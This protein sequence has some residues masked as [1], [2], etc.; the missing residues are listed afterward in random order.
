MHPMK[1]PISIEAV[2]RDWAARGF[3][4][5]LWV[6]PPGREWI[7]YVHPVDELILL[8][9]GEMEVE[10]EGRWRR[11]KVGEEIFI[12]AGAVHSVRNVGSTPTRWLYG[13]RY[14]RGKAR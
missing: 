14:G 3:S 8:L 1:T 2:A 7:G 6:D 9:E 11:C 10:L 4:C 12:P 5:D 13:Y